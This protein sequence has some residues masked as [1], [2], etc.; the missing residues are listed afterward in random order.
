MR[1]STTINSTGFTI[2]NYDETVG[3]L[4]FFNNKKIQFLPEY[5]A[6]NF[7]N[8]IVYRAWACAIEKVFKVNFEN[9]N[10]LRL[11]DLKT[12]Q[13]ERIESDTFEDLISLDFLDLRKSPKHK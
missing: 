12:N 5:P 11:L 9:L 4:H 3:Y 2:S 13:L 6:K 7:P 8:L 1:G 10:K